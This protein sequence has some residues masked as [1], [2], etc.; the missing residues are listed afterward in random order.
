MEEGKNGKR[1]RRED[2]K[3]GRGRREGGEEERGEEEG[4]KKGR[5]K[6]HSSILPDAEED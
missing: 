5:G 3:K 6:I 1:G 2:W 4:W